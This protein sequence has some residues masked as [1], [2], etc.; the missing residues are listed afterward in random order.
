[1]GRYGNNLYK[2]KK[3]GKR[4]ACSSSYL[5]WSKYARTNISLPG[6]INRTEQAPST[7]RKFFSLGLRIQF[8]PYQHCSLLHGSYS[9]LRRWQMQGG[10]LQNITV[11]TSANKP[12]SGAFCHE[13]TASKP[14][15]LQWT[16]VAKYCFSSRLQDCA[17]LPVLAGLF[18]VGDAVSSK[19]RGYAVH[20]YSDNLH[21]TSR[22]CH[23]STEGCIGQPDDLQFYDFHM[24]QRLKIVFLRE[25]MQPGPNIPANGHYGR[26]CRDQNTVSP[27][28]STPVTKPKGFEGKDDQTINM[29]LAWGIYQF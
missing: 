23:P 14:D 5:F 9:S 22:N 13:S 3:K 26:G 17:Y 20:F 7:P 21:T 2:R 6:L 15:F 25:N 19:R 1:M 27:D 10:M 28:A 18:Q 4:N 29:K 11:T 8:S 12:V 24:L 16:L